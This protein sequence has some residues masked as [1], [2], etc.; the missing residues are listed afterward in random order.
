MIDISR[1]IE[2]SGRYTTIALRLLRDGD[3]PGAKEFFRR[4]KYSRRILGLY[5]YSNLSI[6]VVRQVECFR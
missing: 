3:L 1:A 2:D 5:H 6:G 4:A